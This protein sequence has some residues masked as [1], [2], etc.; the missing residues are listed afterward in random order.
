MYSA[1]NAA[2]L[3]AIHNPTAATARFTGVS[4]PLGLSINNAFGRL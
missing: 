2:F 3:N 4:N 1:Q